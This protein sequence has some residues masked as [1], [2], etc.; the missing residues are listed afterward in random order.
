LRSALNTQTGIAFAPDETPELLDVYQPE[1]GGKRAAVLMLHGGGWRV[2]SRADLAPHAEALAKRGFTA[3]VADYRLMP[4]HPWPAQIRDTRAAIK[5]IRDNADDLGIEPDRIAALGYSSGAHL[6]ALAAGDPDGAAAADNLGRLP[7]NAV[8]PIEPLIGLQAGEFERGYTPAWILFGPDPVPPHDIR[9]VSPMTYVRHDF[10]PSCFFHGAEDVQ[11]PFVASVMMHKALC[12][13]GAVSDLHVISTYSHAVW[14][15]K[16]LIEPCMDIV[17]P[18]LDRT[19]VDPDTYAAER[20]AF[21]AE[22]P[23]GR[24]LTTQPQEII[25]PN[26]SR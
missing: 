9:V 14:R 22:V 11:I 19:M 21:W 25:I 13:V 17:A 12:A 26:Q 10:P 1:D 24:H 18:F 16:S 23:I 6:V 3:V 20:A 5:W 7:L 8:I 2:G 4:A 15:I